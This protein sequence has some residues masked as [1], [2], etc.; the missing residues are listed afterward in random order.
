INVL[1][2]DAR[3]ITYEIVAVKSTNIY[4]PAYNLPDGSRLALRE[5]LTALGA[6]PDASLLVLSTCIN[7]EATTSDRLLILAIEQGSY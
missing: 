1:G 7:V 5:Y 2:L 6:P 3:R 4:D